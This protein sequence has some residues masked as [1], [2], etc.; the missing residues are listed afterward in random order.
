MNLF[1]LSCQ[2]SI[3]AYDWVFLGYNFVKLSIHRFMNL[4]DKL[5]NN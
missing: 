4:N 3:M 2:M 5:S 1:M